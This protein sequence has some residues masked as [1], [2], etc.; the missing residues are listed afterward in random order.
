[1]DFYSH[2]HEE[3][4][5]MEN[6]YILEYIGWKKI[7]NENYFHISGGVGFVRAYDDGFLDDIIRKNNGNNGYYGDNKKS[8]NN[9]EKHLQKGIVEAEFKSNTTE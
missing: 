8:K 5:M 4:D 7:F 1:M 3:M 2:D 6:N 9:E